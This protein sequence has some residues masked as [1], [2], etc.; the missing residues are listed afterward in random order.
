MRRTIPPG[1]NSR[2]SVAHHQT[3][4]AAPAVTLAGS[5]L[6][7]P[8]HPQGS[9]LD[10]LLSPR[11]HDKRQE[12][13]PSRGFGGC[14]GCGGCGADPM[15]DACVSPYTPTHA[16]VRSRT[17]CGLVVVGR[18]W[19]WCV[20]VRGGVLVGWLA[21]V[22]WRWLVGVGLCVLAWLVDGR[23]AAPSKM[24]R[25]RIFLSPLVRCCLSFPSFLGVATWPSPGAVVP[26]LTFLGGAAFLSFL[27]GGAPP[28]VVLSP[29]PLS[30]WWCLFGR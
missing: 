29:L 26:L 22:G 20:V 27:L 8:S 3:H 23:E 4:H 25:G 2:G 14:G 16:P 6:H 1:N 7:Q 10:W 30:G 18:G 12:G 9:G 19:S 11:A 15:Y 17:P 24:R 21:V 5:Q 13:H 28:V